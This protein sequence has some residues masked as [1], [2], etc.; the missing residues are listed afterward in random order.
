MNK[1]QEQIID[2]VYK[3]YLKHNDEVDNYWNKWEHF[4]LVKKFTILPLRIYQYTS[5]TTWWSWLNTT[6][7]LQEKCYPSDDYKRGIIGWFNAYFYGYWW[8]NSRMSNE[9]EYN[10]YIKTTKK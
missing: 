10:D 1:E 9:E 7:I 6:Y 8:K 4:R 2:E 5:Q 3:N